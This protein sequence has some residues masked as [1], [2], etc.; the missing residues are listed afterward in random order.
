MDTLTKDECGLLLLLLRDHI[1]RYEFFESADTDTKKGLLALRD[2]L[3][4]K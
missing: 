3:E 2:K 4:M 1:A